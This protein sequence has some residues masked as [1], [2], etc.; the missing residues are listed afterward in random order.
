MKQRILGLNEKMAGPLDGLKILDLSRVM[1]G[2]Y[3]S[4]LLADYG[5]DVIKIEEPSKGDETRSWYPPQI[6][7]EAAYYLSA[8][9]NKRSITINLG[10]A[11]GLAIFYKLAEKSDVILE[12][13]RP[14]VTK[15]L[16][17]DY[18]SVAKIN[19]KMIYC[20]ISG[21]GQTGP[22]ASMPGYDLIVF[23]MGGIMSF[24]GEIGRPPVRV[25]VPLGD[26]GAGVFAVTGILAALNHRERTGRGQ[27]IDV[28]MHDVQ[29]SYLTHQA[30]NYI[31]TGKNPKKAGS[32]HANLAPY[33][34]FEANDSYFVLAVGNDK[35]WGD[36]CRRIGKPELIDDVR[37]RTNPDRLQ[38]KDELVSILGNLFKGDS[39]LHWVNLAREAGVPAAPILE[40]SQVLSD[41]HVKAREMVADFVDPKSGKKLKLLGTPVKFSDTKTGIR[42]APPGLGEHTYEI[43]TQLGYSSEEISGLKSKGAI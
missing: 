12:N 42:L 35:L 31:A 32:A 6:D 5:A 4:M 16:R 28:S 34:A 41:P 1:A 10:T 21:F 2:P 24:T 33:Q 23:A 3:A 22:Y 27:Y 26:M 29:V 11:E 20:S 13:F 40:V 43:L 17:I 18:G 39:S 25:N 8:N 36:F 14:G 37:F 7:G 30:M 19:K 15:K 38:N 9:R